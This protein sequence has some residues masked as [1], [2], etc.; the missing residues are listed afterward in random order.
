MA[1]A[2]FAPHELEGRSAARERE[3][4]SPAE[5]LFEL[6]LG[7]GF[8][9]LLV[10]SEAASWYRIHEMFR[11]ASFQ[12]FGVIGSAIAVAALGVAALRSLGG[13]TVDGRAIA[14]PRKERTPLFA[15]YALGGSCFGLGWGL[16]GACP[17]PIFAW[18]GAGAS[19][20]LIPFAA[21]LAGTFVYGLLRH[22]LPH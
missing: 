8:G 5:L 22:R 1:V 17:G 6:V 18:L 9:V 11:F 13:V 3:S 15:R 2:S 16:L 19:A 14:P 10:K 7:V 21:A 12:L 20:Y 4:I